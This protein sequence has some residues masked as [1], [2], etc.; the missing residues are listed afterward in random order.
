MGYKE[1]LPFYL[2]ITILL[3]VIALAAVYSAPLLDEPVRLATF[4]VLISLHIVAHWLSPLAIHHKLWWI[5]VLGQGGLTLVILGVSGMPELMITML[6]VLIGEAVGV[7]GNTRMAAMNAIFYTVMISAGLYFFT[8]RQTAIQLLGATA[9]TVIFVTLAIVLYNRQR[10]ARE[11]AQRLLVELESANRQLAE[12]AVQVEDLTLSTERQRMA[13]E[14]HDTLAQG[15]AGLILQLEA[16]QAHL[17]AGRTERAGGIVQQAMTRA[18]ST[19]AESRAAI[20][21]LR[22]QR[23]Q[24]FSEAIR[25]NVDRFQS[26]T[27]IPCHLDMN[28]RR[29]DGQEGLPA[30]V[31]ENAQRIVSE[32]LA[33]IMR[34]A[35]ASQ[36]WVRLAISDDDLEISVRDDGIG[37]DPDTITQSGHY[38]LLGMRERARLSGGSLQVE[39][40]PGF[41]TQIRVHLSLKS[42]GDKQ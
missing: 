31:S 39:S 9:P 16:V 22:Q 38:G 21:D 17:E 1:V 41:G 40:Q 2:F 3:A 28:I 19:L 25:Q 42:N 36:V 27:G 33:N 10:S 8:D 15:L 23:M 7:L 35:R 18:R 5:Y 26:A 30:P 11:Q 4:I 13:R 6:A 24:S 37:F 34:H 32:A 20:D 29:S 14:L 12:Y